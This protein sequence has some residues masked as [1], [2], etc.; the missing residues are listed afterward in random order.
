MRKHYKKKNNKQFMLSFILIF[1][2]IT[3]LLSSFFII[4]WYIDCKENKKIEDQISEVVIIENN[5]KNEEGKKYKIDFD[6]L[7]H[8]NEETVAWLKVNNTNIEYA[9]VKSENN[10]FYLNH[11]FEKKYN[12]GGWIFV[13][14]HNNLDGTDKNIVIYGHNM[15]DNSMF[16]TL[17]NI[18]KEEWY[19][20]EENYIIDFIT[21]EASYQYQVFS[22]YKIEKEDYYID[23]EFK[24]NEFEEFIYT[25]KDRSIEDFNID[26]SAEDSI[27][28]LST[29]ADNNKYRLVL[30]AKKI[31]D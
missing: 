8:I 23:T 17:K 18:L 12:N 16:G 5:Q 24:K 1:F 13:D 28:T 3:F 29:C 4:K 25:L 10:S 26:V 20:N 2:I 31:N 9:V 6:K 14:Y 21:E 19:S 27:L 30:H 11:N 7:K 15:K 22:I